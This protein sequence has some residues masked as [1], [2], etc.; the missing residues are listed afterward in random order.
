MAEDKI[1]TDSKSAIKSTKITYNPK[2]E[3]NRKQKPMSFSL[4]NPTQ[5]RLLDFIEKFQY[6]KYFKSF[7]SKLSTDEQQRIISGDFLTI[8]LDLLQHNIAASGKNI[9]HFFTINDAV[10]H[11]DQE[12]IARNLTDDALL[13]ELA[14][15]NLVSDN[16]KD[17]AYSVSHAI[18]PVSQYFA[19]SN[20]MKMPV[21]NEFGT[22]EIQQEDGT[23]IFLEP[24]QYMERYANQH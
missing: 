18:Q 4:N 9:T 15:R 2:Y 10:K 12:E 5:A 3:E 11:F 16:K 1:M 20:T 23:T 24:E 21:V 19:S 7:L 14:N 17:T 13:K 8:P 6:G 22:I